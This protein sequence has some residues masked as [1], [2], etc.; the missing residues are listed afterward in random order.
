MGS[1][2]SSLFPQCSL[3]ATPEKSHGPDVRSPVVM[4]EMCLLRSFFP[5]TLYACV[6]LD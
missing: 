1:L 2:C 3:L 5:P 4:E 6:G